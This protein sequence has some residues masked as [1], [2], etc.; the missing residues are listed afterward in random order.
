MFL[1]RTVINVVRACGPTHL[2][3]YQDNKIS[4]S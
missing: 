4:L 1:G 2:Y 3:G